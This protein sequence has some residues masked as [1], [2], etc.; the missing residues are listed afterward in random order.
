MK[1]QH[2]LFAAA[3]AAALSPAAHADKDFHRAPLLP[4]YAQECGACH[5][6]FPPGM[7]S[8]ASWRRLMGQLDRHFGTDA[9][10]D[11]AIAA[12]LSAWI[13]TRAGTYKRARVEPPQ[14]RISRSA[15]FEREHR[16]VGAA[17]WKLPAVMS[18][19]N[20]A[21]C[22]PQAAQGDFSEHRIR[23]PR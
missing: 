14:D 1:L 17:T 4:V 15:W 9:S 3:T 11:P 6:A 21:A 12:T 22:H 18:A 16:E 7:L 10:L 19:A 5:I 23:I 13:D 20:C 2:L 8:A